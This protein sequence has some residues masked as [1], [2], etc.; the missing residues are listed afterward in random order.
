MHCLCRIHH[1]GESTAF[2]PL[3]K[4]RRG[5]PEGGGVVKVFQ[6]LSPNPNHWRTLRFALHLARMSHKT[7]S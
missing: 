1:I 5:A 6:T 2:N 7:S 4:S 3:L